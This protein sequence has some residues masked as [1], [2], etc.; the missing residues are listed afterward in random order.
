MNGRSFYISINTNDWINEPDEPDELDT[1][2]SSDD[3]DAD[4]DTEDD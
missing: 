4:T 2:S 1:N 3:S